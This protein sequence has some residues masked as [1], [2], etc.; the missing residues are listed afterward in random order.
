MKRPHD[1]TSVALWSQKGGERTHSGSLMEDRAATGPEPDSTSHLL[2]ETSPASRLAAAALKL[3]H[4]YSCEY[5]K[6]GTDI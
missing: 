3:N 5:L 4:D 1:W 2:A 6:Y